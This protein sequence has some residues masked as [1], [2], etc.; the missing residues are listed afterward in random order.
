MEELTGTLHDDAP[1]PPRQQLA[2]H[3]ASAAPCEPLPPDP[4][5][6]RAARSRL[7]D[8]AQGRALPSMRWAGRDRPK[9]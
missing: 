8:V 7:T 2:I 1:V 9:L 6:G 3:D 5:A 4:T